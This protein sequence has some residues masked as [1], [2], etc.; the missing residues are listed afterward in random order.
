VVTGRGNVA[1]EALALHYDVDVLAFTGSGAVGRRLLEYSAR[2]NLKHL[3]LE[4][5]G[6][7]P[8]IVFPD[9]RELDRAAAAAVN[10]IFRN[11][12]QVCISGSRL[13]VHREI[14][15]EFLELVVAGAE[16]LKVGDPLDTASDVGAINSLQQLQ[17]NLDYVN[18]AERE[19]AVRSTG[20]ERILAQSG[21]YYMQPT[22]FSEVRASMRI[23]QEEVFGPILSVIPFADET[24]AADIANATDYGLAAGVWTADLGTAHRMI[25]K[26]KAGVVHVNCYGGADIT[27][28]LGGMKQSGNGFDKS[29]HALEKYTALKTAWINLD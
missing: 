19:G 3:Y 14:Y 16:K 7:S 1:G 8:N 17:K 15:A 27:V 21:G 24:D 18:I 5:G 20:G 23:A 25:R 12:G 22:V 11:S 10:G 6:K 4:L 9:A 26:I 28:P 2:S 29:L 13:L